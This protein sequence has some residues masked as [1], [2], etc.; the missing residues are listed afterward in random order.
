MRKLFT[1]AALAL[2]ALAPATANPSFDC[3]KARSAAEKTV[4]KVPDL[5]WSDR[6]L[7][8][9]YKL[10]LTHNTGFNRYAEINAQREFLAR[11]DK[12]KADIGCLD[13]AYKA[14]LKALAP[15]VAVFG[16]F[17]EYEPEGMGGEMWI[18]RFGYDAAFKILT[19]GGGG[20]TCTFDTD[21]APQGGKGVIR[22]A[23]K[24][25]N[26]CRMTIAPDGDDVMVVQT[27]NCSD[28]CGM[29]AVLDGRY[30]RVP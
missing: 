27:K 28:Y 4:C 9:L 10:A 5:Q 21:S 8:R 14:R 22:Y 15:A 29:R 26:A 16:A 23:E 6:Q 17:A 2:L 12:C 13:A 7:T 24:S 18:V 30:S 20:H 25:A 3:T 1:I 19:V 11:R